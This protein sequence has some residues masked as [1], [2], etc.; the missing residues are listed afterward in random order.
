MP[1]AFLIALPS[2]ALR[3]TPDI[4]RTVAEAADWLRSK[5][6]SSLELTRELLARARASQET[7]GAFMTLTEHAALAAAQRAD[8]ELAQGVDR[9]PLHGIP[10]GIKDIL[11][12]ADAPT[13]A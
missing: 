12:T 2:P 11:A 13:M 8:D 9:G 10:L 4:P 5:C 7:V 1:H 6:V 3:M